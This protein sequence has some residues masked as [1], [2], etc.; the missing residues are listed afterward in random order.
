MTT[1]SRDGK[2][3]FTKG[4]RIA[5]GRP[6]AE[7]LTSIMQRA[8]QITSERLAKQN[9]KTPEEV[10]PLLVDE[11]LA[12]L[13][14]SCKPEAAV[15]E[16]MRLNFSKPKPHLQPVKIKIDVNDLPGSLERVLK[17]QANGGNL[18]SLA[19]ITDSINALLQARA[20]QSEIDL[21]RLIEAAEKN[22]AA[23]EDDNE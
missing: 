22:K 12:Q 15:R 7:R 18:D 17:A 16:L 13:L 2:G 23:D 3:R 4:N 5:R 6:P 9:G 11:W 10:E 14:D 19:A 8:A 21:A 1:D 20:L